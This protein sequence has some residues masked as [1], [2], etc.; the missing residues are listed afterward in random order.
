MCFFLLTYLLT[1]SKEQSPS[2]EAIRFAD[3]QEITR[4]LWNTK[5]HYRI[6]KRPPAV[7]ILS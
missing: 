7:S 4:I 6:H 1:Y 2:S 3:S 5:V